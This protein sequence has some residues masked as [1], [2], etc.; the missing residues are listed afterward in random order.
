MKKK[1]EIKNK[2][3]DMLEPFL[4]VLFIAALMAAGVWGFV[5]LVDRNKGDIR[6]M[7]RIDIV[8]QDDTV[9]QRRSFI[10]DC[11]KGANPLSDEEPEDW[12]SICGDMAEKTYC[13]PTMVL[14][15]QVGT[16]GGG[17]RDVKIQ[18]MEN[19]L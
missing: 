3:L 2:L 9:E 16:G 5:S 11:I 10:I 6:K 18:V 7:Q 12:I 17:W 14:V 4:M 13:Q 1:N 15:T 8:C 19:Q